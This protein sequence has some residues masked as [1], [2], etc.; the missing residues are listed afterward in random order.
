MNRAKL[1]YSAVGVTDDLSEINLLMMIIHHSISVVGNISIL[2]VSYNKIF[3]VAPWP[4][5]VKLAWY[6]TR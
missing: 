5:L 2:Y 3:I 4:K 6:S 1:H